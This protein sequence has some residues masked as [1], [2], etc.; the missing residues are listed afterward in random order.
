M[1]TNHNEKGPTDETHDRHAGALPSGDR[2]PTQPSVRPRRV[3]DDER[4]RMSKVIFDICMSLGGFMTAAGLR[5][6]SVQVHC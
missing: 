6:R 2:G 3:A 5:R 4:S 1:T